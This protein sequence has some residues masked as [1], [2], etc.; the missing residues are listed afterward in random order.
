MI[1]PQPPPRHGVS[2]VNEAILTLARESGSQPQVFNTAPASLS[3][4]TMNRISR[5][6]PVTRAIMGVRT[7]LRNDRTAIVYL[8][9]SGGLG[10]MTELP[11]VWLGRKCGAQTI[12]HHH[13]FRYLEQSS[14]LMKALVRSAG[15]TAVHILL[16]SN[17]EQ[18]M[19][20][21]FPTVKQTLVVS[22][23]AFANY[24]SPPTMDSH[25][26]CRVIGH[27]SNL[28]PEKGLFEVLELATWA[29]QNQLDFEF[30]IAGPFEDATVETQFLARAERLKNLT[31]FGPLYGEEKRRF[32]ENLDVFVFPTRYR[33]E[34]EP[35][36]LLEALSQGCP[37]ISYDRGCISSIIDSDSGALVP[38]RE[39]FLPFASET[40]RLW[41]NDAHAHS[42]RRRA[43]RQRFAKL[44]DA[45]AAGKQKLLDLLC[46][47]CL[48]ET[49]AAA[50]L[51]PLD[52]SARRLL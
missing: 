5:L 36:V 22:N 47:N 7:A 14:L 41:Q 30:R 27:L 2:A 17:M 52:S 10:I 9:V 6:W 37:V 20:D 32:F 40:L 46:G 50:T 12:L 19:R 33:N 34:A 31:V 26:P 43:A 44:Q 39:P 15:P 38:R 13:S 28:S 3:R 23:A 51:R 35:L 45:A 11:I 18:A 1:G 29:E 49:P 24:M 21:K 16:S 4:T 48:T 8:S 25:G 42:K